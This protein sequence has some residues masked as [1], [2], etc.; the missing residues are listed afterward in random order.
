MD[1]L[2][3]DLKQTDLKVGDVL[4][5]KQAANAAYDL[6]RRA[7]EIVNA[8]GAL[9]QALEGKLE[10]HTSLIAELQVAATTRKDE[11][12]LFREQTSQWQAATTDLQSWKQAF[13][14]QNFRY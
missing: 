7:D 9:F 2:R 10:N 3:R 6:A 5:Q 8:Q 14:N 4:Q 13:L 11:L 1:D 12:Q